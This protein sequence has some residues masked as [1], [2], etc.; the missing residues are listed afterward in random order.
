MMAL[1]TRGAEILLARAHR[2]AT[3][4]FSALA[5]FVEPGE[6][7]EDCVRRE[8]RE[9]V[10]VEV[11][12]I[13]YFASQSWAFPHSLMIAYTAEYAGG[14]IRIDDAE[15]AEARWFSVDDLPKLPP[16]R[17]DRA[18]AHRGDRGPAARRLQV[19][20]SLAPMRSSLPSPIALV[21]L[22]GHRARR[23]AGF[24]QSDATTDPREFSEAA[25]KAY[26]QSLKDARALIAEKKYGE[27]IELLD[28]LH[29]ERPREPQARFL[30]GLALA[31]SGKTDA[32]IATFQAVL[33]DYPELPEPHN[34]LAVLYAQKGEYGLARDELEAAIAR[35]PITRSRTRT[36]ATSTR[37]SPPSTTRRRSRATRATSSTREAEARARSAAPGACRVQDR[38]TDQANQGA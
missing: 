16:S 15:I 37:G 24:A 30:K 22:R 35:R 4:M 34:N 10:G 38:P 23:A 25:R 32:A 9:E 11:G 12:E 26:A 18:Q 33:G 29:A 28:K 21:L 2:F 17:V 27:A 13:T 31:D 8:V 19:Y 7:I 14:E 20:N 6:T 3:G 1:V 5:G 36:W